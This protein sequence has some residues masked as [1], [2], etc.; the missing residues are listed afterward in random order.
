MT[1]LG[2]TADKIVVVF[3]SGLR[4][5][6]R[7][8]SV[9][10]ATLRHATQAYRVVVA[11]SDSDLTECLIS[12]EPVLMIVDADRLD[13]AHLEHLVGAL[14]AGATTRWLPVLAMVSP[15]NFLVLQETLRLTLVD[16]ILKPFDPDE[17]WGRVRVCLHQAT[18]V[19][20]LQRQNDE[21][22][23]KSK[24]DSLTDLYNTAHI[25]ERCDGEVSRAKRYDQSLSC[26]LIDIDGFKAVNDTYGHPVG[27]EVLR[28]LANLLRGSIRGS[29]SL[30][31]YGGEEFLLVLPQTD[32]SGAAMLAERLRQ[33]VEGSVFRVGLVSVRITISIGVASFPDRDVVGRETLLL[34]V[35]RAVYRAKALGR[36]RVAWLEGETEVR[37]EDANAV[38]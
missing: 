21:L 27:N 13:S 20:G 10:E 19:A 6:R 11:T 9:I 38:G 24:T 17:L 36:N 7:L 22:A 30:G 5:D 14:R 16:F 35:D 3:E 31:R 23:R 26:L 32:R 25:V 4:T 15:P 8:S 18:V 2:A 33:T 12:S 1:G 34:A 28:G 29:D 37:K